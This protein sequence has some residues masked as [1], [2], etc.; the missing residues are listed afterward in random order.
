[1]VCSCAEL[2]WDVGCLNG[3]FLISRPVSKVDDLQHLYVRQGIHTE[4]DAAS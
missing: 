3:R 1:M 4:E 2:V